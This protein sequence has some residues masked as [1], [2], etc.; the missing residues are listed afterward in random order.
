[1]NFTTVSA[2]V[3]QRTAILSNLTSLLKAP[4]H[5]TGIL[6]PALTAEVGIEFVP[7]LIFISKRSRFRAALLLIGTTTSTLFVTAPTTGAAG[8]G[9]KIVIQAIMML[10]IREALIRSAEGKS[11]RMTQRSIMIRGY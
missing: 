11:L 10:M 7:W 2:L 8:D 5:P 9:I 4:S 1:V 3:T 6:V